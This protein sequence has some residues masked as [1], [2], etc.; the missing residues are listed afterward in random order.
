MFIVAGLYFLNDAFFSGWVAGG[1]PGEHKLGWER[2]SLASLLYL[3]ACF[4]GAF[5]AFKVVKYGAHTSRVWLL[6]ALLACL[7]GAA[8]F[9]VRT[10]HIAQCSATGGTWSSDFLECV[11]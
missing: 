6:V 10:N 8:P 4:I 9:A 2:R 11:R 7:L 3:L 5:A 1:P